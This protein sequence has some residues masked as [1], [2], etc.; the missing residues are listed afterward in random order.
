VLQWVGGWE[1]GGS[2]G[3]PASMWAASL[4]RA[5]RLS[6]SCI[7]PDSSQGTP[8]PCCTM[9]RV[10]GVWVVVGGQCYAVCVLLCG[11][12]G[13]RSA[14]RCS[15]NSRCKDRRGTVPGCSPRSSVR[16]RGAGLG[17]AGLGRGRGE[18]LVAGHRDG[19]VFWWP[20]H[21]PGHHTCPFQ[22]PPAVW[23]SA[24]P[25]AVEGP[26]LPCGSQ[27]LRGSQHHDHTFCYHSS[28]MGCACAPA[29]HTCLPAPA[30][31]WLFCVQ[32]PPVHTCE[33]SSLHAV[34]L[35]RLAGPGAEQGVPPAASAAVNRGQ[36]GN[37]QAL[38]A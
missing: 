1:L 14:G 36:V 6:A 33:T 26:L 38:C 9:W 5:L 21:P 13:P 15:Q 7:L 18:C 2:S 16:V 32:W 3:T 35:S 29:W 37:E 19:L 11:R 17:V 31:L 22:K 23:C 28:C 24:P 25:V 20:V 4:A 34:L 12:H 8:L 30:S 27:L 10:G